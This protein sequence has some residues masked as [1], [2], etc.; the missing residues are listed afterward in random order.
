MAKKYEIRSS[1]P[2][3]ATNAGYTSEI[4]NQRKVTHRTAQARNQIRQA[5]HGKHINSKDRP[6]KHNNRRLL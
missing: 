6:E 4:K 3:R 2:Y 5:E 1:F